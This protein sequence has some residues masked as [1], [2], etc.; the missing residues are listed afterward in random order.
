MSPQNGFTAGLIKFCP[1]FRTLRISWTADS[2]RSQGVEQFVEEYLPIIRQNN[3]QIDYH[4]HR[5]HTEWDPWVVGAFEWQRF[6][7]RRC[8]FKTKHQVLALIEEMAIGGDYR[9][10]QKRRVQTRLPR[11]QEL[12]STET[13]GHNVYQVL[14]KWKADP[15]EI[16]EL[17]VENHPHYVH[18]KA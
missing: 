1:N 17:A 10:G 7:K 5:T 8:V 13:M 2:P 3:P 11:G 14:S 12:W 16:D 4:L 15:T 18:R 6:R 9:E